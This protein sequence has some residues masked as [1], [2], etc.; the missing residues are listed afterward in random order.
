MLQTPTTGEGCVF[1]VELA[2]RETESLGAAGGSA[3]AKVGLNTRGDA[4]KIRRDFVAV[5]GVLELRDFARRGGAAWTSRFCPPSYSL[6]ALVEW[7]L[8]HRL[9]TR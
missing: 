3:I 4:H 5:E 9:L 2:S 8:S 6:A 7:Q 1:S